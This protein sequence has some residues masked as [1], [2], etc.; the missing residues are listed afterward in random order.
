[1]EVS[2]EESGVVYS[3]VQVCEGLAPINGRNERRN[4]VSNLHAG[5][6]ALKRCQCS[7]LTM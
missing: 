3:E 4:D 6:N 5:H 2:N 1:M 7:V